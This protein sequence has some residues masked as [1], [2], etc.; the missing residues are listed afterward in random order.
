MPI[1][2][3]GET[4]PLTPGTLAEGY[5]QKPFPAAGVSV[6]T[7]A[8]YQMWFNGLTIGPDTPL[9]LKKIEG[10][11]QPAVRSGDSGRPRTHGLFAGLDVMGGREIT[12]TGQLSK[13]ASGT[14]QHAWEQ[15]VVATVPG[16]SIEAPLYVNLP[17]YGTLVSMCRMRRRNMPIDIQFALGELA[18]VVLQW[19][20][21]DPRLYST[22]TQSV[23][24]VAT[25]TT[26][27]MRFPVGFPLSFG[28]ESAVG[29]VKITNT[30]NINVPHKMLVEGPAPNPSITLAT[31]VGAPTLTFNMTLA[32]GDVLALDT[33]MHT[34]TYYT[35]GTTSG[36]SRLNTLALGSQWFT[37][38]PG[39]NEIQ[40]TSSTGEGKLT[41]EYASANIL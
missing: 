30:G 22:P 39:E 27:G 38:P 19:A 26:G 5:Y 29:A 34:A 24:T 21:S 28:G 2:I 4:T 37:L 15:L 18:D 17:G 32:A 35:A 41:I 23:T 25:G 1:V 7:L 13:G 8:P 33:D 12:V 11:D 10:L 40:F 36:S 3:P 31:A 14:F 9:E 6:P 16:G 20:A